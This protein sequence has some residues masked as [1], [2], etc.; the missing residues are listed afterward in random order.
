MSSRENAQN[1]E[2]NSCPSESLFNSRESCYCEQAVCV[3][4]CV[5][6]WV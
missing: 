3:C 1:N 5:C 2:E 4:V 6:V